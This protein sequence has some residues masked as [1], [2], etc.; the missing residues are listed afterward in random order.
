MKELAEVIAR[1]VV[2]LLFLEIVAMLLLGAVADSCSK[3]VQSRT[4]MVN[5]ELEGGLHDRFLRAFH[6]V[7]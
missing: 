5:P 6:I 4:C 1:I 3:P 7:L 2:V